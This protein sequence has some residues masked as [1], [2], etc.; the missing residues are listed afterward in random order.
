[1]MPA[2]TQ[3]QCKR[4]YGTWI[5]LG[6]KMVT[7]PSGIEAMTAIGHGVLQGVRSECALLEWQGRY[8][9]VLQVDIRSF[10]M[11][12]TEQAL[13]YLT[14][15]VNPGGWSRCFVPKVSMLDCGAVLSTSS[16]TDAP[17]PNS[18]APPPSGG[19]NGTPCDD[20]SRCRSKWGYCGTGDAFCNVDSTWTPACRDSRR[21]L[22]AGAPLMV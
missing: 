15:G 6:V 16:G 22:A 20:A 1:M 18:T 21:L 19:C 4:Q 8:V 3:E 11:E 14:G 13:Q 9:A 2:T 5:S 12:F 10:S 17:V 7:L